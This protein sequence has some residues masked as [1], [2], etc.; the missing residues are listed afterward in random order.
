MNIFVLSH[1]V[2]QAAEWH[3]DRHIVKMPLES[4]QMLCSNLVQS[5]IESP[6]KP[7]HLK[8]PCTIWAGQSSSNFRWLCELGLALCMEYTYRY[9]KV[10][11][12][13]EVINYCFKFIH[14]FP[15]KGLTP[16]AQAMPD[17]F[18]NDNAIEAYRNYYINAKNHLHKWTNRNI[19]DWCITKTNQVNNYA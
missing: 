3:V 18:K 4:A 1:D 14:K 19:P 7:V 12:C 17:E 10:H 5:G 9:N 15:N 16:F 2:V 8:H 6:Y 13:E 11:K